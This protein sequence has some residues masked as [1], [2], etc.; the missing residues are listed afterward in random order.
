[1]LWSSHLIVTQIQLCNSPSLMGVS[2]TWGHTTAL[3]LQK[4]S[5]TWQNLLDS[6]FTH[7]DFCFVMAP[8]NEGPGNVSTGSTFISHVK[9][10]WCALGPLKI[11][12]SCSLSAPAGMGTKGPTPTM[13]LGLPGCGHS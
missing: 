6:P 13:P 8:A 7:P 12:Q 11:G 4:W 5:H 3:Q 1:M 10:S 9:P 2:P